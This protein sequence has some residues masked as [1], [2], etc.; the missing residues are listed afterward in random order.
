MSAQSHKG[1]PVLDDESLR[2][3]VES[4]LARRDWHRLRETLAGSSA[5]VLR[6]LLLDLEKHDRVLLFRALPRELAAEVFADF[7]VEQ[8]D[9]LVTELT[10]DEMREVLANLE[11]DDRTTLLAELPGQVTRR[12]LN[13]LP[14]EDR[15]EARW[16]LGYPAE[17]VGRLMT[18]DYVAVRPNWTVNQALDHIRRHGRD[19]ETINMI[20]V[21]DASWRLLDDLELRRIILAD[22][23]TTIEQ[24][25]DHSWVSLSAFDNREEAVRLIQRYDVVAL[26]VVDSDG[27]LVGIVTVD[28]VLDVAEEEATEDFHKMATVGPIHTSL[29]D[30]SIGFLYRRRVVWLL[31]LVVVNIFSG[32][33]IAQFE[34]TIAAVIALV[35]FLPLLIDSAGNAGSQASTLMVRA[36]ATG[37]VE[38]RDWFG[39]LGRELAVAA[40]IGLTMSAAV[41]TLGFYRGGLDV[42]I[43]VAVS[44]AIVVVFG[45]VIGMSLPFLLNRFG[46]DPATASAPLVTSIADIA[47]VLV[48]F[49]IASWY[50]GV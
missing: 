37:D 36:L 2:P 13:L 15:W 6:D 5:P 7:D 14:P 16:L 27:V 26:P 38:M 31:I 49:S 29:R 42:G 45:S 21:T 30:A 11:P 41:W 24:L 44:M 18:P 28:D 43:I 25:M 34:E 1:Q 33:A 22:P 3:E 48:Y 8:K 50:L 46:L 47:G 19:S 9:A 10:D 12:L 4:L 17:S 23:D 40:A 32:A 35:F 39:L 20:Y